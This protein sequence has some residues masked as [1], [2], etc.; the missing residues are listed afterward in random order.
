[1]TLPGPAASRL[2]SFHELSRRDV[3]VEQL[4]SHTTRSFLVEH[5]LPL[6]DGYAH[7]TEVLC[8]PATHV[9]YDFLDLLDEDSY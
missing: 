6:M 8:G 4:R 1:M 2:W 9:E 7:Q 3:I 5:S